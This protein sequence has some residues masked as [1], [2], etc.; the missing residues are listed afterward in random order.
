MKNFIHV[1]D[2][3]GCGQVKSVNHLEEKVFG[4]S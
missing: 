1:T 2:S 3:V 4:A